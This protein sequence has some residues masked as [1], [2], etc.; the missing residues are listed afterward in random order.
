MCGIKCLVSFFVSPSQIGYSNIEV[1]HW[2][3]NLKLF[4]RPAN[5]LL[6]TGSA[7]NIVSHE[8][9]EKFSLLGHCTKGPVV[10]GESILRNRFEASQVIQLPFSYGYKVLLVTG[11][12]LE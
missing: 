4:D 10:R 11:L 6:D 5:I 3:L 2:W 7:Y 8:Y 9:L 1:G 12:V